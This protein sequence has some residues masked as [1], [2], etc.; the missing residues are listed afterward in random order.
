MI[1]ISCLGASLF[2]SVGLC[3]QLSLSS[4]FP[5]PFSL[6]ASL[7]RTINPDLFFLPGIR[8]PFLEIHTIRAH[9]PPS[10]HPVRRAR[11]QG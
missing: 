3:Y 11:L 6:P 8:N 4:P 2:Q 10:R 1:L 9:L 7:L 5:V